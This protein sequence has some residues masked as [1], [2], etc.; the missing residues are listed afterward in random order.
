MARLHDWGHHGIEHCVHTT[1]YAIV[2]RIRDDEASGRS[3]RRL[4]HSPP[5][6]FR[7][8]YRLTPARDRCYT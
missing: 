1:C 2:A 6:S 4:Q 3:M 5:H 8:A 7:T